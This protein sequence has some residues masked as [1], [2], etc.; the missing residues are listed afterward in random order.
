M[1]AV[2]LDPLNEYALSNIGVIYLKRQNYE[3]CLEF[4]NLSIGILDSFHP[5]TRDFQKDNTLEVKLL[6]RRAKCYEVQKDFEK[7]KDDLDRCM[8]LDPE[9]P[10]AKVSQQKVQTA[11]NTIKFDEYKDIGN[12][13]L[14]EKNFAA[15]LE[16]Y[17]KCLRITRKA[18]TLDNM[19]VYVN[20]IACL[21]SMDK[22]GQVVSECND[23]FRLIKNFINKNDG[24]HTHE[25]LERIKSMELRVSVRKAAALSKLGKITEAIEEYERALV[26][27]P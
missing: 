27:D 12:K 8:L 26:L 17:E 11:L 25:D 4:T 6:M 24:K 13:Y 21:L 15:S 19:A 23:A 22:F 9:N 2:E 18:T 16:Y 5:D 20:K 14:K 10:Q 3:R 1:K 7:A